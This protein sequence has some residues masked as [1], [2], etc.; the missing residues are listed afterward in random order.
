MG[1]AL[2]LALGGPFLLHNAG[3][4]ISRAFELSRCGTMPLV[5]AMEVPHLQPLLMLHLYFRSQTAVPAC[6]CQC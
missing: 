2:Q 5:P 4:Y 1:V 3:A 6:S